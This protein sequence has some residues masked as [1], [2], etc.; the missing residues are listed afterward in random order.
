[1]LHIEVRGW[2]VEHVDICILDTDKCNGKAL[3]FSARQ[4]SNLSI[5]DRIELQDVHDM[6]HVVHDLFICS[7]LDERLDILDGTFDGLGDLIDILRFDYRLQIVLEDLSEVVLQFRSTPVF[8]NLFP[9]WGIVIPAQ[10]WLELSTEDLERCTLADAVRSHQAKHLSRSWRGQSVEL[11]AVGR[12]S[13]SDL[14]LQ[15]GGQ[16]D[17]VDG[18]ERAF[19]WADTTTDAKTLRD[20]GDLGFG[21]DLDAEFSRAYNGAASFALLSTFLGL[22][23]CRTLV[24]VL[25]DLKR[26]RWE[27]VM[28]QFGW[29]WRWQRAEE[30]HSV[31]VAINIPSDGWCLDWAATRGGSSD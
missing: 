20:E 18:T 16:V 13:V 27:K 3:K 19:L 28:V 4:Q 2:L 25:D 31:L 21:R 24:C 8:E 11:E 1:L 15:V 7:S 17:D 23:L 29:N 9:V 6:L 26:W 5:R 10:V 22:A 30:D 12:V 14:G